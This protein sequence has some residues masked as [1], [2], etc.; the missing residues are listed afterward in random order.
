MADPRRILILGGGFGGTYV[1]LELE[2]L[3]ARRTDVEV[4]L[5]TRE[6]FLLFT[7]MLHE[8]ASGELEPSTIIN[9]LRKLLSRVGTFVGDV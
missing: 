5:V 6:N 9:P 2:R 4:T 3:L 7:P 8:V 1:A